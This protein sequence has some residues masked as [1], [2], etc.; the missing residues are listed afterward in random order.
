MRPCRLREVP[1][2][3]PWSPW[4]IDDATAPAVRRRHHWRGLLILESGWP[5]AS[6]N[7]AVERLAVRHVALVDDDSCW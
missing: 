7:V 3:L 5:A 6:R 1:D 4:P 2:D